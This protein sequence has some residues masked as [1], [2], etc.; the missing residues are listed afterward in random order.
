MLI[1]RDDS[2]IAW[3]KRKDALR[4]AKFRVDRIPTHVLEECVKAIRQRGAKREEVLLRALMELY[5]NM[6]QRIPAKELSDLDSYRRLEEI[7]SCSNKELTVTKKLLERVRSLKVDAKLGKQ[8]SFQYVS[9]VPGMANDPFVNEEARD[10]YF[11]FEQAVILDLWVNRVR[12]I[13]MIKSEQLLLEITFDEQVVEPL[14]PKLEGQVRFECG[15]WDGP[16]KTSLVMMLELMKP[17]WCPNPNL[18][19]IWNLIA[20]VEL[21]ENDDESLHDLAMIHHLLALKVKKQSEKTPTELSDER[22]FPSIWMRTGECL[23]A[24]CGL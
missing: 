15:S 18:G 14:G 17:S 19:L 7:R 22:N 3:A 24:S 23:V 2:A 11:V 21:G 9:G 6:P 16:L 1:A 10:L 8:T 13:G 12:E 5:Q 20:D 4:F